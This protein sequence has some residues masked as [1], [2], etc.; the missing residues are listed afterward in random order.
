MATPAPGT[1][2]SVTLDGVKPHVLVNTAQ[3]T[4]WIPYN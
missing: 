3:A 1:S 4:L 2:G